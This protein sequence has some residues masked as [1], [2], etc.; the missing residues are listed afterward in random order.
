MMQEKLPIYEVL[1]NLEEALANHPIVILQ[2]PPGAGKSTVLPIELRKATWLANQ[3]MVM[4]QPRR[5]AARS[6]ATRLASQMNEEVGQTAGYRVRFERIISAATKIEVLTEG[7]LSRLIQQDNALNDIGLLIFDEFHERS[8]QADLALVLALQVQEI[9][10]PDLRILIMS[11]TLDSDDLSQKLGGAPVITTKGRQFP[12]EHRYRELPNGTRLEQ[13]VVQTILEAIRRDEGDILV[14]LPGTAEIKRVLSSLELSIDNEISLFP[15]YGDLPFAQQQA[16]ILPTP[17]GLRKVVLATTIAETSLTIEGICVVIDAGLTRVPRFDPNSGL[18]RLETQSVTKDAA[19]Q[20]AGRAGRLGPGICYRLWSE[21]SHQ[22]LQANRQAEIL[23]ADLAPLVL[24]LANW[25]SLNINEYN[26]PTPPPSTAF[27]EGKTLLEDLEALENGKITEKGRALLRLPTHPRLAFMLLEGQKLGLS[28][29]AC[30]IAALLE[31]R[32][33][34]SREAGSDLR[35]RL[36]ALRHFRADGKSKGE[37]NALKRIE[38]LSSAWR[39]ILKCEP[40]NS[41][42]GEFEAGQLLFAAYP[43]RIAK[44]IGGNGHSYRLGNSRRAAL[45]PQDNLGD[46]EWLAIGLMAAGPQEGKIFQAAPIDPNSLKSLTKQKSQMIWDEKQGQI[47][48]QSLEMIG[49]LI[50]DAK[51][52]PQIDQAKVVEILC[53]AIRNEPK[54]LP[55]T[56]AL[57]EFQARAMSLKIWRANEIWPDVSNEYLLKNLEAWLSPYIGNIRKREDF[58]RLD[59]LGI[60]K[61]MY[62]WTQINELEQLAPAKL[63]VPTGSEIRLQYFEDGKAPILAVRLQEMFGMMETPSINQGKNKVLI[64]LLSP[65][66]KPCAVT[67]DLRSFWENAYQDVRKDLRGRYSKHYWPEDPFKAEPIR[68]TKKSQGRQ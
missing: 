17:K 60:I 32:D 47:L 51:P 50:V 31:E 44:R 6:V 68:G 38:K 34:L 39:K 12:I 52:L 37:P 66:F 27:L 33:P 36:D 59:L 16:A 2:A 18:T 58:K 67:Q 15:L 1:P 4:L 28:G 29:M 40:N 43:E 20:R 7:L 9:L 49:H 30:D 19:A 46:Y 54:L 57:A 13:H 5:L 65:G 3:K 56:D 8:L 41:I 62:E 64:H 21:G 53:E 48:A 42:V 25:G 11:A 45:E 26:W 14:F 24:D 10:R 35:L 22:Y 55:W 23:Q 63:E 61:G